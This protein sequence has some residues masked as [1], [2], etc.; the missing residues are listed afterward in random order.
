ME[1]Y[2]RTCCIRGYHVYKG[3]WD[4]SVGEV[5]MCV[6]E[7]HNTQDWYAVAVKKSQIVVGHLPRKISRVLLLVCSHFSI[8]FL[9]LVLD[10]MDLTI[11][12]RHYLFLCV[13]I[14]C[15]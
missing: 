4:A 5:L 6:R 14:S 9:L 12:I 3:K 13:K 15:V 2:Q 10:H 7:T 11:N 1:E 8:T